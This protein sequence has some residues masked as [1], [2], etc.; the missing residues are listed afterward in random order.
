MMQPKVTA[1]EL[2]KVICALP[3]SQEVTRQLLVTLLSLGHERTTLD[4][5][6]QEAVKE[7]NRRLKS[8]SKHE[9]TSDLL[10]QQHLHELRLQVSWS[11]YPFFCRMHVIIGNSFLLPSLRAN[12]WSYW[13]PFRQGKCDL[14][15]LRCFFWSGTS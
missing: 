4:D 15:H 3:S 5:A 10:W 2:F 13:Y 14:L 7:I 12:A 6:T 8:I 1:V 9:V 11:C